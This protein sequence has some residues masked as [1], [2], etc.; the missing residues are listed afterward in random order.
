MNVSDLIGIG[1][2]GGKDE[3]GFYHVMVKPRYRQ[4]LLD[5]E[6]V[7]LIFNS[8]RVFFVTIS[9]RDISDRR[10]RIKFAE[11][12]V[13]EERALHRE[14]IVAIASEPET[15]DQPESLVGYS[16]VFENREVGKVTDYFHNNAQYVLVVTD[17]SG[18]EILIPL[19]DHFVSEVIPDPGVIVLVNAGSLLDGGSQ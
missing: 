5:A 2:L 1:R 4:T 8:D 17:P 11:E 13:A 3:E 14:T 16:V 15:E 9:D 6:E 19:V 18:Q 7:F 10:I 12:G